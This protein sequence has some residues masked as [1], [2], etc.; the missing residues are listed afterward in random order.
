[1]VEAARLLVAR[2]GDRVRVEV[3][4]DPSDPDNALYEQGALLPAAHAK[5]AGPTFE[6]W[7]ATQT[8]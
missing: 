4:N 3:G 2:R 7:V 8:A 5:L 1:M 6:Q